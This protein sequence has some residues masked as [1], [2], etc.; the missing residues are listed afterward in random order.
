MKKHDT[1]WHYKVKKGW[2]EPV[3]RIFWY[4][5]AAN[6]EDLRGREFNEAQYLMTVKAIRMRYFNLVMRLSGLE[7]VAKRATQMRLCRPQGTVP[8]KKTVMYRECGH[9]ICPWCSA[10]RLRNLFNDRVYPIYQ[11]R[12]MCMTD[13]SFGVSRLQMP[14]IRTA[15]AVRK[16]WVMAAKSELPALMIVSIVPFSLSQNKLRY[17]VNTWAVTD[18]PLAGK[19]PDGTVELNAPRFGFLFKYPAALYSMKPDEAD[20]YLRNVKGFREFRILN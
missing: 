17:H 5:V 14:I 1:V 2:P 11:N 7:S 9:R 3:D 16:S 4:H 12:P 19:P 8:K 10:R 13:L 20:D 6:F 18:K 15:L